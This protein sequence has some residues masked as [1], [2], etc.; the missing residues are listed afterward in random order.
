MDFKNIFL[1]E[2][3][4]F[5]RGYS[6]ITTKIVDGQEKKDMKYTIT[7]ERKE[8]LTP[9][10]S[11]FGDDYYYTGLLCGKR[12]NMTAIDCDSQE[13]YD[14]V[15]SHYDVSDYYTIKT[16]K[17]YHIYCEYTDKV[18]TCIDK[19]HDKLDIIND[20]NWLFAPPTQYKL[21]NGSIAQYKYIGGT[22][23]GPFPEFLIDLYNQWKS[24]QT[25]KPI[26]ESK[27]KTKTIK[28]N[29][30]NTTEEEVEPEPEQPEIEYAPLD[31]SDYLKQFEVDDKHNAIPFLKI[32]HKKRISNYEDWLKLGCLIFSLDLPCT[33][34]DHLSKQSPKYTAGEC[35]YKWTTFKTK[36]YT[37]GTLYHWCKA[38]NSEQ[39]EKLKC[40]K[41]LLKDFFDVIVDEPIQSE[42]IEYHKIEERYL[43]DKV[44]DDTYT[45]KDSIDKHLHR[46][47]NDK[48]VSSLNIKSPYGTSKT[49]LLIKTIE[50]YEPK[51][52]LFLSYRK[53]LTYDLQNNFDKLGFGNYLEHALN[54]KRLIVQSE[55]LLKLDSV[56][57]DEVPKFDLV[58]IDESES[59]LNNFSSSTFKGKSDIT[60]EYLQAIIQNCGKLITLD[61]DQ[62]NRT[63]T[64]ASSFAGTSINIINTINF[65]EKT[66][67]LTDSEPHFKQ[68]IYNSINNNKKIVICSQSASIAEQYYEDL[69]LYYPDLKISLYVGKTDDEI[70]TEHSKNIEV[71]WEVDILIYSP[72]IE[73]GCNFDADWFDN[74]YC[75]LSTKSSSQRA[76]FQMLSRVRRFTN[77]KILTFTN[78]IKDYTLSEFYTYDEV[79]Q[80]LVES[81]DK[82]LKYGYEK[83]VNGIL[84]RG[85]KL[86]SYDKN[87]IYNRVE[88]LN[89]NPQYY[90]PYFKS[91]A[92][93]KGFKIEYLDI[94]TLEEIV[95]EIEEEKKECKFD[96]LINAQ[97]ID[98]DQFY[99]LLEKQRKSKATKVEKHQVEKEV[100]KQRLGVSKLNEDI[101]KL[102]H[103]KDYL[104]TNYLSLIDPNNDKLL[105]KSCY[106][107]KKEDTEYRLIIINQIIN[108]LGFQNINDNKVLSESQF[109][110]N[111]IK[112]DSDLINLLFKDS[113]KTIKVRFNLSKT[114]V[115]ITNKDNAVKYIN[116]LL[117]NY[118]IKLERSYLKGKKKE[119]HNR[120]YQLVKLNSVD[121]IIYNLV[122]CKRLTLSNE[123]IFVEPKQKIFSD[124]I[125]K[126][127]MKIQTTTPQSKLYKKSSL[128]V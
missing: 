74:C 49:Q 6:N 33:V 26:K 36:G 41:R 99:K 59:V 101:L 13:A 22:K 70:K 118:S 53:S 3:F 116:E 80:A 111:F 124:L 9:E 112:S 105:K 73:A 27:P 64:F 77:N 31:E 23:L 8:K 43:L 81:R 19:L 110:E 10:N 25:I 103:N 7:N 20:G 122:Q 65:N 96:Y 52:I 120:V 128:D 109:D 34:W 24:Q 75:I 60:Y 4:V 57:F 98:E 85:V 87:N 121:E 5:F 72:C 93:T 114:K 71:F 32:L 44:D 50:K 62:S 35:E 46:L 119:K 84:R 76:C 79:K 16:K 113:A 61:G 55:S 91:L 123:N 45:I 117:K 86:E 104:I 100:W 94:N 17:G 69:F 48:S 67:V 18:R 30:N 2:K 83:D 28:P 40:L 125:G 47:F 1:K 107:D 97:D 102:F 115:D 82:V 89:K 58:I 37:I 15:C 106:D 78:G 21:L 12:S 39:Y 88:E 29:S 92:I 66:I 54:C 42:D 51:K 127:N 56:Y 14:F 11:S 108:A 95:E 90:L 63:Y 38:D 68:D 126:P